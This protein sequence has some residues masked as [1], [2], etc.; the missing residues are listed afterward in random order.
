M[1]YI[2]FAYAQK[3]AMQ[4]TQV[5]EPSKAD[6]EEAAYQ[7]VYDAEQTRMKKAEKD[8]A[9]VVKDE[10]ENKALRDS[11]H[12]KF[13]SEELAPLIAKGPGVV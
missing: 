13:T 4:M 1:V 5:S 8:M 3:N 10:E 12:R 9:E 2:P 6:E 7:K 11:N